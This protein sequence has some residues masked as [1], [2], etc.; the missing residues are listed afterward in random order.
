ILIITTPEDQPQFERLLGDGGQWG[1]AIAYAV[2]PRPEGL[3]QAFLIGAEFIGGDAVALVLGANLF[4]G[5]GL[6]EMLQR[7]A[8]RTTGATV[9][10]Y[11]VSDP[12]R[13]GVVSFNADGAATAIEEKP[14]VPASRW[15]VTGLYFYDNDVVRHAA[16]VRP[17]ARGELEISEINQRYLA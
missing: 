16:A 11:Q 2:Q 8:A 10:A 6:P 15:A 13:Y 4:F 14:D 3:A 1:L 5:H 7:G 12:A 17:S 9:F